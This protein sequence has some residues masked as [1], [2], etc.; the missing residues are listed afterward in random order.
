MQIGISVSLN[1]FN[2]ED[3]KSPGRDLLTNFC[4]KIVGAVA[5]ASL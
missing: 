5:E 2:P 4:I 3:V 1:Q